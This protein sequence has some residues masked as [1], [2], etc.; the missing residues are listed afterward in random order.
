MPD[1]MLHIRVSKKTR[2]QMQLLL[3]EGTFN[4]TAELVREGIRNTLLKYKPEREVKGDGED[5]Q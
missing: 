3:D 5:K 1:M 4:N 2:E